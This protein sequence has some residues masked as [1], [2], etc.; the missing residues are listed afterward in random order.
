ME[1]IYIHNFVDD[2][3][4]RAVILYVDSEV[5]LDDLLSE[6]KKD[7]VNHLNRFDSVRENRLFYIENCDLQDI[8]INSNWNELLDFLN[9][10]HSVLHLKKDASGFYL[11]VPDIFEMR[12][13]V[14][15]SHIS[16]KI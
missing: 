9:E 3:N 15:T 13:A 6:L 7:Y 11:V 8:T 2:L 4:Y 5:N 12:E 1:R 10:G 14:S 16:V